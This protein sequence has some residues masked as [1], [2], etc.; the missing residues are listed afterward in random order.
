MIV[1]IFVV[2]SVGA[3]APDVRPPVIVCSISD[4]Q[5]IFFRIF[6]GEVAIFVLWDGCQNK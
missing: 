5:L 3:D 4:D 6:Y 1:A 2:G